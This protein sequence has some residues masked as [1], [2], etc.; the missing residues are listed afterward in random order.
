MINILKSMFKPEALDKIFEE[1]YPTV[2]KKDEEDYKL[3]R[4]CVIFCHAILLL[5]EK[6]LLV[7]IYSKL[8]LKSC[9]SL[10]KMPC[11]IGKE[12]IFTDR[13]LTQP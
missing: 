11:D 9:N 7:L 12:C 2:K 4:L 10:Y 6:N 13:K 1:C 5:F 8:C 3:D